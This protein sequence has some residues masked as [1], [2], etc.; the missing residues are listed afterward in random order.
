MFVQKQVDAVAA[1]RGSD[2]LIIN[3]ELP[4]N[5]SYYFINVMDYMDW[6]S[7]VILVNENTLKNKP[8][9]VKRFLAATLKG[10]DKCFED[11]QGAA[12][13]LVELVPDMVYQDAYDQWV[14]ISQLI[15][16]E[17][18]GHFNQTRLDSGIALIKEVFSLNPD[19]PEAMFTNDYLP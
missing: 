6:Y 14:D 4:N 17:S 15:D 3:R 7:S 8:D 2:N 19:V 9:M 10:R 18:G 16:R 13:D 11:P 12:N 5:A 1:Y